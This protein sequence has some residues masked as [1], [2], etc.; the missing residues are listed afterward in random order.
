MN[1]TYTYR[2]LLVELEVNFSDSWSLS[3]NRRE[4]I[5]YR[6]NCCNT[7]CTLKVRNAMPP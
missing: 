3:V 2:T 7:H 4:S 1:S 6:R 5:C